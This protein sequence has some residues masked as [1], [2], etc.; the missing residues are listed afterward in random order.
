[1]SCCTKE[2]KPKAKE[3]C[4]ESKAEEKV[5]RAT[6]EP[7]KSG[8]GCEGS[9]DAAPRKEEKKEASCC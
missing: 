9:K 1:M 5:A 4:C 2:R 8:C 6:Q 3:S 7:S